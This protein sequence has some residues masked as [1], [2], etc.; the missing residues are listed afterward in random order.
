MYTKCY[1]HDYNCDNHFPFKSTIPWDPP[2][3][4]NYNLIVYIS[5]V[6]YSLKC[7]FNDINHLPYPN[8]LTQQE[9][10]FLY[11]YKTNCNY[12]IKPADKGGAYVIWS[13]ED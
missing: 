9:I 2:R 6:F 3:P 11:S 10:N 8:Y 1:F 5:S 12:V 13:S 4:D 7:L